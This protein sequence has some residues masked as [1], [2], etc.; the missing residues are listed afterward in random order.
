MNMWTEKLRV[1]GK[2]NSIDVSIITGGYSSQKTLPALLTSIK[3]QKGGRLEFIYVENAPY[4]SSC[5]VVKEYFPSAKIIEPGVNL[6]F[7]K[8]CNLGAA[9]AEGPY[10]LAAII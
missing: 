10:D 7:S 9:S 8:G 1:V 5:H 2:M 6:G 3:A 4:D